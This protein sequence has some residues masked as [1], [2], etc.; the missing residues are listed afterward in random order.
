MYMAIF[1]T[2]EYI[3]HNVWDEIPFPFPYFNGAT[4]EVW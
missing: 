2:S 1:S 3:H 4:A